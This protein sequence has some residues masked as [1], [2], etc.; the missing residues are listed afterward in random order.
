MK[1]RFVANVGR[2]IVYGF[3]GE[4]VY[5]QVYEVDDELGKQLLETGAFEA[6]DELTVELKPAKITVTYSETEEKGGEEE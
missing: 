3:A 2:G 1:I 6:V 4:W 5:G